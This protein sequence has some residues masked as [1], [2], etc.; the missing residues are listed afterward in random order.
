MHRSTEN[1]LLKNYACKY[2]I[3]PEVQD[4]KNVADFIDADIIARLEEL[5]AEEDRLE[6]AGFYDSEEEVD[7]DEDA[8][9]TAAEAI[10]DRKA[11]IRM[12]NA[13]K[14]KLQNRPV[15]P[16]T[17]QTRTLSTMAKQLSA[18]GY[19]PSS[20]EERARVLAKAR[21]LI[22]EESRKRSAG[23]MEVDEDEDA[24]SWDDEEE[25]AEGEGSSRKRAK[26]SIVSKGKRIPGTDR[27]VAGLKDAEVRPSSIR[28]FARVLMEEFFDS[29]RPR[30]SSFVRYTNVHR[31]EWPRRPSP[32]VPSRSRCPST[33]SL[34]RVSPIVFPSRRPSLTLH[35]VSR[36][37]WKDQQAIDCGVVGFR[38]T[39]RLLLF[40][41][42]HSNESRRTSSIHHHA[43]LDLS[44]TVLCLSYQPRRLRRPSSPVSL[45]DTLD[46]VLEE[47]ATRLF[48]SPLPP[49]SL[50]PHL[51]SYTHHQHSYISPALT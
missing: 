42:F 16:R 15:I 13:Q 12:V 25:G 37:V 14:D 43:V 39:L 34:E 35:F 29:K 26:T 17:V 18:A 2:D 11:H 32:I 49:S 51:P 4:G 3:M 36:E 30:P 33:Y 21:G 31:I 10:R 22:G 5:E 47:S 44:C 46:S 7:S 48:P 19:D 1:Y 9:R 45:N 23:D 38:C 40:I 8:I 27:Q 20:L 50:T 6:A 24:E 28:L 41:L